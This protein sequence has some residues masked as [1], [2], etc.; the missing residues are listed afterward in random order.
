[1][2]TLEIKT[3][4][5]AWIH[6]PVREHCGA[7]IWFTGLSAAGKS[8]LARA[9]AAA[10][11]AVGV[12]TEVLDAD[13]M[14]RHLN[15]DLG[16]SKADRDENIRRIAYVASLLTRH[17]VVVLVAAIS[18]YRAARDEA[19]ARIGNLI[20]VYVDAPLDICQQRDPI[21]LYRRLRTGEISHIAGVDDP[22]EPPLTPEV[23][24]L[25]GSESIAACVEQVIAV[26][27]DRIR[28]QYGQERL[29]RLM[30]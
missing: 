22:Y 25:T 5:E 20:E 28:P 14:R 3:L 6:A 21:G 26:T 11:T 1:M 12:R 2:S 9:T 24:C 27:L 4:A 8:T 15:R 29:S 17:E 19:R 18:P 7:T 13:E 30:E 16:F 10:L 23:H